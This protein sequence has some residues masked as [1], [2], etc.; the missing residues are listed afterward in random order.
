MIENILL[1]FG[2][3]EDSGPESF[4]VAAVTVFVGPNNSGKSRILR[5]IYG[6]CSSGSED[7]KDK[8]IKEVRF[9][10]LNEGLANAELEKISIK[11]QPEDRAESGSI[12]FESRHGRFVLN[13]NQLVEL[14]KNPSADKSTFCSSYLKHRILFIDGA[15]RIQLVSDQAAGDLQ[16]PPRNNL[17]KLA[18]DLD[19]RRRLREL[20]YDAFQ[21]Y[22]VVDP[23]NLGQ[24]RLRLSE[25]KPRSESEEFG[26]GLDAIGFHSSAEL[27]QFASD[28][29]KAFTGIMLELIA[30]DPSLV[31]IDEP[32]AFLYPPL[33]MKLGL[34]LSRSVANSEK[35]VF[36][37]TH[38]P[39][40]L[41]G[42]IQSGVPINIVRLTY[43]NRKATARSLDNQSLRSLMRDPLLRSIG[44]LN[45]LF[46]DFVV[47]TEG[48][49]DRSFYHEINERLL[50]FRPDWGIPNCL[51]L[52]AQ[53]KQNLETIVRPL[54][55]MGIP[56]A[57]IVDIDLLKDKGKAWRKLLDAARMPEAT[58]ES[59]LTWKAQLIAKFDLTGKDMKKE[60]GIEILANGERESCECLFSQLGEY[61]IFVVP[62]G[63][64]ESWL[65]VVGGDVSKENWLSDMF[66]KMGNEPDEDTYVKPSNGD[67]W[68]FIHRIR[69]WLTNPNRKGM[70]G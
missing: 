57:T 64:V 42:C 37:S 62:C 59:C 53:G 22:L 60:G 25:V 63:E 27:M 50:K 29:V 33:A 70:A 34:E 44:V 61:G 19:K 52:N 12:V 21:V 47:V 20:V 40:F 13:R 49:S 36:V 56:T 48:D 16:L 2:K 4:P 51:F 31:I 67:V 18:R 46:Y 32:E 8:I 7:R 24:L 3:S 41:M 58:Q 5:E 14:I 11:P 68:E 28:G 17:Q 26:I 43:K 38:S 65:K 10:G 30:G 45:G 15:V 66:S 55:A 69:D 35:R 9:L 6:W 54:R 1:K 39:T 23:T